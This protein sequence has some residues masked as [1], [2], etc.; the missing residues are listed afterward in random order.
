VLKESSS[1][2]SKKERMKIANFN[3]T[4]FGLDYNFGT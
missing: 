4:Q 2:S 1:S 3:V